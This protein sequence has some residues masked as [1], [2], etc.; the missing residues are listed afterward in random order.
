MNMVQA[1]ILSCPIC[2]K[3]VFSDITTQPF[4][5][6]CGMV[7][8]EQDVIREEIAGKI[9]DFCCDLCLAKV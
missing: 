3:E 7:V 2:E 5:S 6:V 8:S 1:D 9:K 4:C